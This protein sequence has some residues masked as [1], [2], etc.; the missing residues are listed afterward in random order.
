MQPVKTYDYLALARGRVL[1]WTRPLSEEQYTRPFAIGPG[2]LAR[3]LTHI[4]ICEWYYVRRME[5]L[6]TPP[7]AQWPIRDEEPPR[8]GE[9]EAAWSR[10]SERTQAAIRAVTDWEAE[11][12]YRIVND[13]GRPE[14][15]TASRGDIFTQLVLHEVHHRAQVMNMLRQLG[16]RRRMLISTR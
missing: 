9:L 8:F 4:M 5:G 3:T 6:E 16:W 7:Y 10:Q 14:I 2:S 12:E 13:E 15:I 11:L 1:E